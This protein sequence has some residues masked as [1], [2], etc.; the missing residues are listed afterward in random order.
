M[1]DN[2][3][4][5]QIM[6]KINEMSELVATKDDLDNFATK[7][8]FQRLENKIDT[9]TNRIDELNIKMDKQY[10]QV[11]QNTQ[12]IERNFKQIAKNSEQL[13]TLN[14][15]STRQDDLIA[16]LALRAVEQESKLRS[17]IA[18]S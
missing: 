17:H 7:Q 4:L 15:H 11:K 9:N 12:L 5:E 13:D 6:T 14:K 1:N 18:H 8:D 10:D 3:M 16:T 2:L